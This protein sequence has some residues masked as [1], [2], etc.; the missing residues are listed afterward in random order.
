MPVSELSKRESSP[1]ASSRVFRFVEG[2]LIV[3]FLI[4]ASRVAFAIL[5][6][7][8][9]R[10]LGTG[11]VDPILAGSHLVLVMMVVLPWFAPRSRTALP[12]FLLISALGAA[13]ARLAVSAPFQVIQ[14][15][16]SLITIGFAGVYLA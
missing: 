13:A 10:A 12:R 9:D 2:S 1:V 4:Q 5:L 14:L 6:S 3:L 16:A 8:L 11:R 15:F 7:T